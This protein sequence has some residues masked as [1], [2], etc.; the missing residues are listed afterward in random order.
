M[1]LSSLFHLPLTS[2]TLI[3]AVVLG[4][5]LFSPMLLNR[6]RIPQIVGLIIAGML[7]G[8]N[9][10]HILSN[11][12]SFQLFGNVGLLYVL[13]LVGLEMDLQEVKTYRIRG[14]VFAFLAFLV[15]AFLGVLLGI[16]LF[17]FDLTEAVFLG[18]M[19]AAPSLVAFPVV[20]R[21]GL[22]NQVSVRISAMA[23]VF[24]ISAIL[25]LMPVLTEN[26]QAH[27]ETIGWITWIAE[28]IVAGV[29]VFWLIPKMAH[30]FFKR[31]NDGV[32]QYIFV[33]AV[34][35]FGAFFA[36]AIYMGQVLGAFVVGLAINRLIPKVSPLMDRLEFVGNALFIPF[37]LIRVGM[38]LDGKQFVQSTDVWLFILVLLVVPFLSKWL[39][40][41]VMQWTFRM[42]RAEGLM[43]FGLSSGEGV[44]LLVVMSLGY[45]V[46]L[47]N[48]A[49]LISDS[50]FLA[51]VVVIF[52]GGTFST[53]V[54]E[55][56]ARQLIR[57]PDLSDGRSDISH[58]HS[59]ILL[60]VSNPQKIAALVEF[61]LFME[62]SKRKEKQYVV[63]VVT[64]TDKQE[65]VTGNKLL[66]QA[67]KVAQVDDQWLE[68]ILRYNVQVEM[69]IYYVVKELD[70]KEIIVGFP[71]KETSEIR[72]WGETT[73]RL[74]K[75]V[76]QVVIS[77]RV[78]HN[79]VN[80][81]R[82][83]LFLPKD[84][85]RE[86]G[87]E[88]YVHRFS[89]LAQKMQR[90]LA[91]YC[92][93]ETRSAFNRVSSAHRQSLFVEFQ[94]C[95]DQL[96]WPTIETVFPTDF[97]VFSWIR[98]QDGGCSEEANRISQQL[99]QKYSDNQVVFYF[100]AK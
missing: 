94:Q 48:G 97:L 66:E 60:A 95:N 22:T 92:D 91:I 67:A 36:Q 87:F 30:S 10:F 15:P 3:F 7:L 96:A 81:E 26:L 33:I 75:K 65:W 78:T 76:T 83:V 16:Y 82:I 5:I 13:F 99:I 45:R 52:L 59:G 40:S 68:P 50:L 63:H 24:V 21:F 80:T 58:S 9:G 20:V 61:A 79:F 19:F 90:P 73:D 42:K 29:F 4:V 44:M 47:P 54:T 18:C 25:L 85:Q 51:G 28:L 11:D 27:I 34:V 39:V 69:G 57:L 41:L 93:D 71:D 17:H 8:S 37:F 43:L 35:F 32:L 70:V 23:T 6:L 98:E 1:E 12:S 46:I 86:A 2:P 89:L 72:C 84:V 77:C 62:D 31:F 88:S 64:A 100:F 55:R 74:L 49:H 38:L 56:A 14:A 53:L